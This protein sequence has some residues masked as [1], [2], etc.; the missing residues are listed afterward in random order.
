LAADI[1]LGGVEKMDVFKL[2]ADCIQLVANLFTIAASGIA[3]VVFYFKRKELSTALGLLLSWS[4]HTTL[5]D[6]NGKL[7]RLN[8][9]NA[10]EQSDVQ[11][12][13]NIFHEI[14]GQIRGNARLL[15][16]SPHMPDRLEALASSKK[17]TEQGKR[18]IVAEIREVIRNLQL[19]NV[20]S[21]NEV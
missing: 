12:I 8:E 11:E 20:S 1:E 16:A 13:K 14:A 10:M 6:I 18:S 7:D 21:R 3:I 19:N 17:L 9:Y 15:N 2:I 5:S 4:Y